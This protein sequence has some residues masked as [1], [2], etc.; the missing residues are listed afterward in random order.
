[1]TLPAMTVGNQI[2][3]SRAQKLTISKPHT[4]RRARGR[5]RGLTQVNHYM[6][7][8][9]ANGERGCYTI[10]KMASGLPA[11]DQL[12]TGGRLHPH[13]STDGILLGRLS[14]KRNMVSPMGSL[15]AMLKQHHRKMVRYP[16][17]K[18]IWRKR[19]P[20]CNRVDRAS[21]QAERL[22]NSRRSSAINS[23]KGTEQP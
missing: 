11:K 4:E 14:F 20:L 19:M 15:A 16:G 18:G 2:I 17:G 13:R 22:P 3:V 21:A 12:L 6:L 8:D 23:S 10:A 7:R 9:F 1:M 5:P